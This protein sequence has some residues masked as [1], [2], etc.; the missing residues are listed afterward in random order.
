MRPLTHNFTALPRITFG[1]DVWASQK[2]RKTKHPFFLRFLVES[3]STISFSASE[4]GICVETATQSV[5]L[6]SVNKQ[7]WQSALWCVS[8]VDLAIWSLSLLK[9]S[10]CFS[11]HGYDKLN[12]LIIRLVRLETFLYAVSN[13]LCNWINRENVVWTNASS[14]PHVGAVE[15]GLLSRGF[16][17]SNRGL[18]F[19]PVLEI[20]FSKSL[21]NWGR[22]VIS[23]RRSWIHTRHRP[24]RTSR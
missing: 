18:H 2:D 22:G 9:A 7:V 12:F 13:N 3:D 6:A 15:F 23:R 5:S 14:W 24:K 17:C 10:L 19:T 1:H 20:N 16:S 11:V 8:S 21:Q 4:V